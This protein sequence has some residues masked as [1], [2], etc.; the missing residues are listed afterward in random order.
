MKA[1]NLRR[2]ESNFQLHNTFNVKYDYL[3]GIYFSQREIVRHPFGDLTFQSLWRQLK[4]EATHIISIFQFTRFSIS[5][6]KGQTM[7]R[8][9]FHSIS[10]ARDTGQYGILDNYENMRYFTKPPSP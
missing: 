4:K 1:E 2:F 3:Q 8:K 9:L 5:I 10:L 7:N 6:N